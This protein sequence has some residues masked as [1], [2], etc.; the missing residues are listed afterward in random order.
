MDLASLWVVFLTAA[1]LIGI[2]IVAMAI[3][4]IFRRAL[5]A[6]LMWW[7]GRAWAGRP[8]AQL[9]QLP[10]PRGRTE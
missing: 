8:V 10:A 3:G 1:V 2:A 4:V 6:R 5:P 7:R 9:R